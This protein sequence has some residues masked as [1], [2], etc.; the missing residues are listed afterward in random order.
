MD[1]RSHP[2]SREMNYEIQTTLP[3]LP[4]AYGGLVA[5][6]NKILDAI[7]LKVEMIKRVQFEKYSNIIIQSQSLY[8]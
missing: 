8:G 2:G 7:C 6:Q 5:R 4:Q 1:G 3:E